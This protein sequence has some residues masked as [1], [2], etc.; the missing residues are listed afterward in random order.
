ME[1]S[2]EP[3]D[4][5][6]LDSFTELWEQDLTSDMRIGL[7]ENGYQR[8]DLKCGADSLLVRVMLDN[9]FE[10]VVYTRGSFDNKTS[11]CFKSYEQGLRHGNSLEVTLEIP[12]HECRTELVRCPDIYEAD[13]EY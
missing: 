7:A 4:H 8:V 1:S 12:F 13:R 2:L 9:D 3:G 10:G 5:S 11:P 6:K